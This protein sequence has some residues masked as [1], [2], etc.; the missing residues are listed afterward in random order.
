MYYS[1]SYGWIPFTITGFDMQDADLACKKLRYSYASRYAK[2][3]SLGYVSHY[4]MS[5]LIL[6]L[7][8]MRKNA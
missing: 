4:L 6:I 2:V 5:R 1:F 7:N 8:T 3:G